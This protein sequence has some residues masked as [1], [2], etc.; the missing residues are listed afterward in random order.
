LY[1]DQRPNGAPHVTVAG[2]DSLINGQLKFVRHRPRRTPQIPGTS[3]TKC[4]YFVLIKSSGDVAEREKRLL[5]AGVVLRVGR[6]LIWRFM[7]SRRCGIVNIISK[8]DADADQLEQREADQRCRHALAGLKSIPRNG[9]S[10]I[11][12]FLGLTIIRPRPATPRIGRWTR[13]RGNRKDCT[14]YFLAS[15]SQAFALDESR[16]GRNPTV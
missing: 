7:R 2:R 9:A 8:A 5:P 12:A 3:P 14:S 1:A 16:H 11:A 13:N 4:S 6:S 10:V 15:T